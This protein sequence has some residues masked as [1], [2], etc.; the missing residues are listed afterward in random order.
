M[1][2]TILSGVIAGVP[3]DQADFLPTTHVLHVADGGS[4]D[5][6]SNQVFITSIWTGSF[7]SISPGTV[8]SGIGFTFGLMSMATSGGDR[9]YIIIE[10]VQTQDFFERVSVQGMFDGIVNSS[11]STGYFVQDYDGDFYTYWYWDGVGI[12]DFA[13]LGDRNVGFDYNAIYQT[14]ATT[15]SFLFG[16]NSLYAWNSWPDT[17]TGDINQYQGQFA[18]GG[19]M[20]VFAAFSS[21]LYPSAGSFGDPAIFG[22]HNGISIGKI[23][24][25]SEEWI[26]L[27][28]QN[29]DG[30]ENYRMTSACW[31]GNLDTADAVY[32]SVENDVAWGTMAFGWLTSTLGW[33]GEGFDEF[34]LENLD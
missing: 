23:T 13:S 18:Q 4:G 19:K 2:P 7:G 26:L 20:N 5:Y 24:S 28:L 21:S 22:R 33:G 16:P 25:D 12:G 30:S 10:G 9:F 29:S 34:T 32:H 15:K 3:V 14:S 17:D 6:G 27:L 11:E 1:I 8:P 31:A